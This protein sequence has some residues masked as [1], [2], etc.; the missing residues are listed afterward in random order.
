MKAV[1]AR[2]VSSLVLKPAG[3]SS[4]SQDASSSHVRFGDDKNESK[5]A[6]VK[7]EATSHARYYGLI[8][9]NQITLSNK[10]NEVASRLIELYFEVFREV[11]GEGLK[12]KEEGAGEDEEELDEAKIEKVAGKV[13]KWRGRRKGAKPKGGRK[14]ALETEELVET[15]EA[16][17][18]AAVLTGINRALPYAKLD[19][20]V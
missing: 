19:E 13:E 9:L 12:Q 11:L 20:A 1:V 15:G 16:K 4:A 5:K 17:L 2:E 7:S 14:S 10:D 8:T 18:V 6:D 3:S